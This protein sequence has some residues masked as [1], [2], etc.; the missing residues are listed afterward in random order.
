MKRKSY[1]TSKAVDT[2]PLSVTFSIQCV[3]STKVNVN[4]APSGTLYTF[5][6]GEQKTITN[7]A[8]YNHLLSLQKKTGCCGGSGQ[9]VKKYFA[10]VN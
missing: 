3:Y 2:K 10:A 4:N 8:D 6:P 5:Q 9:Q 7:E 1:S